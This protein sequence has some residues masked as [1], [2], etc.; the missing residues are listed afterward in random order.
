[1]PIDLA[2]MPTLKRRIALCVILPLVL[3]M[4]GPVRLNAVESGFTESPFQQEGSAEVENEDEE[5]D[6]GG[7]SE[8]DVNP[9]N[10]LNRWLIGDEFTERTGFQVQGWLQQGFTWNPDSPVDRFNG[11]VTQNDRSNEYQ[12]NQFY[13]SAFRSVNRD[14]DRLSFGFQSDMIYGTDAAF[15]HSLGIDD[16]LVSDGASRFY[17]LALPQLYAEVYTPILPGVT[18]QIGKWYTAV[19]YETGL[20]TEDFF[21]SNSI[22]FLATPYSH[23]GIL[24]N[25]DLSE[26]LSASHGLHRGSDVWNDNNNNLGYVGS[27]TW[28]SLDESSVLTFALNTGPEQDESVDWQDLDGAPGPDSPGERLNRVVYSISLEKQLCDHLNYTVVHDYFYQEGSA[29][30]GIQ[31]AEA[32]GATQYLTYDV[33]DFLSAGVRLE[34]YRDDDGF[35]ASGCRSENPASA[36]VYTNLTMGLQYRPRPCLVIRPEVRWDWQN[37]DRAAD[38]PAFDGGTSSSQFLFALDATCRF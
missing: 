11:P 8:E 3:W 37:R 38:P 35:V 15:F 31:A 32:Y 28:T 30:H 25:F 29:V 5:E 17:K 9:C 1:M 26:Q 27:L 20:A 21:Y 34:I 6:E 18:F 22:S 4:V 33:D 19:G 7:E 10:R 2:M 12:L 36:G 13:L 16:R 24:A 23:T 14:S